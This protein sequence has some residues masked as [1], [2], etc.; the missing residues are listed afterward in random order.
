M[1]LCHWYFC[2]IFTVGE[3]NYSGQ[4]CTFSCEKHGLN[5]HFPDLEQQLKVT[6]VS[7]EV[8][9]DDCELYDNAELVSAVYNISASG[10]LPCPVTVEMQHCVKLR[11]TED[12]N[13]LYFVRAS[14]NS[15]PPYHFEIVKG[16]QFTPHE[17]YGKTQVS[18]FS[19]Y[20]IIRFFRYLCGSPA[21]LICC[22]N[23][24]KK[25][26]E[27]NTNHIY[28]TVTKDIAD[29]IEVRLYILYILYYIKL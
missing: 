26:S 8:S 6:V 15:G 11:N 21:P 27:L 23:V 7:L 18:Q 14:S 5:L 12:A 20:A 24:F 29:L 28:I 17:R 1:L 9:S 25:H 16:G 4:K 3:F 22:S 10:T 2:I 19:V 13:T